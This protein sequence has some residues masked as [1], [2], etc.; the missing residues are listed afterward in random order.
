MT[1]THLYKI[2]RSY[3]TLNNTVLAGALVLVSIGVWNTVGTLQRNYSLQRKVDGLNR[4]I[5]I[6][7]LE[8]DTLR[9]QQ[10]FLRSPEYLELSAR[11]SL[12]KVAAGEKVIIL[13]PA[14][15]A[16]IA[17]TAVS[18]RIEPSNIQQW[19]EFFFGRR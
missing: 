19:R 17:A 2:I 14:P 6:A 13:P 18:S 4:Q 7:E 1:P 15:V 16:P 9:L 5:Q 8:S 10:Q 12:G 3:A 11:R